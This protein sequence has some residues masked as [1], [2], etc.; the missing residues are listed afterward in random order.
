MASTVNIQGNPPSLEQAISQLNADLLERHNL[1]ANLER[2]DKRIT[3]MQNFI[4]GHEVG[5]VTERAK[6]SADKP[7]EQA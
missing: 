7:A 2:I 4:T 3:A 5:A 1:Q 6:A